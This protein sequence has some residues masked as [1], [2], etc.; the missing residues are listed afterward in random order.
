M[1]SA[2]ADPDSGSLL[3]SDAFGQANVEGRRHSLGAD[4]L[5]GQTRPI[6]RVGRQRSDAPVVGS[7]GVTLT[8]AT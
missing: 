4:A 3:L 2:A 7:T 1:N 8:V 6:G 5:A